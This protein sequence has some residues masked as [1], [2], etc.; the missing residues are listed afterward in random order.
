MATGDFNSQYRFN[1]ATSC[2]LNGEVALVLHL[3]FEALCEHLAR[4]EAALLADKEAHR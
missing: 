4:I 1:D 3:G 2:A